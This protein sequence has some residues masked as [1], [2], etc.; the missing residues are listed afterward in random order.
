MLGV[1]SQGLVSK[2]CKHTSSTRVRKNVSEMNQH[3]TNHAVR[4]DA[5]IGLLVAVIDRDPRN[6]LYPVLNG[7]GDVRD[8]LNGP[9]EVVALP[10]SLKN[11]PNRSGQSHGAVCM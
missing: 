10:L 2:A 5:D 11:G 7:I 9:A 1:I 6:T 3:T 4:T 8:D